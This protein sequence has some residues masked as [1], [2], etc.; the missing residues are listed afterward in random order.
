V[1]DLSDGTDGSDEDLQ[2]YINGGGPS[3]PIKLT[4]GLVYILSEFKLTLW[5]GI[6]GLLY[7]EY[8]L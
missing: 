7:V 8:Y 4:L 3:C 5:S 2:D 1:K 6:Q